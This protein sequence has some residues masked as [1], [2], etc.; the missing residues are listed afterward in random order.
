MLAAMAEQTSRIELGPLVNCSSYRNPDLQADMART[1]DH[2]SGGRFIFGTGSGWFEKDYDAYGYEFGTVGSRLDALAEDLPRIR[3]RWE[4]LNPAPVRRIPILIGGG[5]ERKTLKLVAQ[6]ADIWHTFAAPGP[7]RPQARGARHLVRRGRSRPERD[8]DLE[9]TQQP[10]SGIDQPGGPGARLRTRRPAVRSAGRGS[11]LRF[12]GREVAAGLAG[13]VR[14]LGAACASVPGATVG[15]CPK[16]G[17]RRRVIVAIV[18]TLLAWASAF[19]VIRG[20]GPEI[21]GGA[22]ALGRLSVGAVVLGLLVLVTRTWVKPTGREWALLALYGVAWFGAYNVALNLA[23]HSLD[24]G[25]TAMIVNIGPILIAIGAGVFLGEG[26][27]RPLAIGAG[28]AF[29]GVVLIGLGTSL[30]GGARVDLAGVLWALLAAVT[31]ATGVLAQKPVVRR[32]PALQATFVGCAIGVLACLPFIG[33]LVTD[34]ATASTASVIGVVYLGLVPTALAFTTWGYALA[35]VPAGQLGRHHLHRAAPRRA[36]ELAG[37]PRG[38]EPSRD[39]GRRCCAWSESGSRG[40]DP[41]PLR[42]PR[43]ICQNSALGLRRPTLYQATDPI[44]SASAACDPTR[45]AVPPSRNISFGELWLSRSVSSGS[46]RS[47]PPTTASSSPTRA[48]SAMVV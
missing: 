23:E 48:P 31:Y 7:A 34:L 24:A 19:I 45:S 21:G 29:L 5:G 40:A 39:R 47:A 18:I 14:R 20:V 11:G 46:V 28:V 36:R 3:A 6:H 27:P 35:R 4:M 8:R 2:I 38:S 1:I 37:V 13:F 22:L 25:T 12:H 9:R 42:G 17:C 41:F 32:I 43:K 15:R 16:P 44:H 30:F 26:I 10:G 33:Q